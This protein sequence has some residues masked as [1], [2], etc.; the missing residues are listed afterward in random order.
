M[1]HSMRHAGRKHTVG[2]EIVKQKKRKPSYKKWLRTFSKKAVAI[3]LT[4]SIIDLQLSYILAFLGKEQI[5]ESLSS[6]IASVIIG[7]M[8]GYFMKALFE[9]F[10]EKREKRLSKTSSIEEMEE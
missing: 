2:G 4:I 6:E 3:I 7:V 5:A 1:P 8:L 10:F 9:T